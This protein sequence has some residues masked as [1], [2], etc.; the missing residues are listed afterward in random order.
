MR[1][2]LLVLFTFQ[3]FTVAAQKHVNH[4]FKAEI[5]IENTTF[6]QKGLYE[7]QKQNYIS[8][9]FKPEYYMDWKKGKYSF[10]VTLFGRIDQYDNRRTHADIRELYWRGVF[11]KHELSVGIK[12]I[13]WGVAESNHIVNIINQTDVVENFDGE[14]KLG[15]PMV[16]YSYAN[17]FG[18]IDVFVMP[19]F[20]TITF[21]GEKGRFRTPIVLNGDEFP[22]ESKAG[23]YHPDMAIRWSNYIGIF[24]I[25]V[26]YFYGTHRQPL[27][28]SI[29]EF[30]PIYGLVHQTGLDLQATTGP[31]LWKFEGI[32]NSNSIKDYA[33][34][35][36]GLEYTFGNVGGKGLDIGLVGE[37]LYD[38]RDELAFG[39]L[40]NDVFTGMRLA[41]NDFNSTE[42]LAGAIFDLERTSKLF[43][44]EASRR[45]K[46]TF[47][48]ELE[49]RIFSTVSPSEFIYFVRQD[50]Y[51]QF[52]ISKFF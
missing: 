10:K 33:V 24:D 18:I 34:L 21:P 17:T 38:S 2:I 28:A 35:A 6:F 7:G 44:I 40:Q 1:H 3:V 42:I 8:G 39:S 19:Y 5:Q 15:Q 16:H 25:G 48:A 4:D 11:N 14:A 26:S 47:K 49:G 46:E 50:S 9:S 36:T 22:I 20:R 32:I 41:F 31:I 45:I 37:Y 27:I 23:K 51:L 43:S 52:S 30:A 13:Y 29:Y 12:E